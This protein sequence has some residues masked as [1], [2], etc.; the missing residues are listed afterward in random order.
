M[1]EKPRETQAELHV[2]ELKEKVN[3]SSL[4]KHRIFSFISVDGDVSEY[5]RMVRKAVEQDQMFGRFFIAEPDFEFFNFTIEELTTVLW[6]ML[7][8]KGATVADRQ[9]LEEAVRETET[10]KEFFKAFHRALPDHLHI[11]KGMAW[12][13]ALVDYTNAHWNRPDGS[14]RQIVSAI[15]TALGSRRYN[16]VRSKA[17]YV[18]DLQTGRLV[19][20][21]K[22]E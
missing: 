11:N 20:K 16:Y 7:E 19:E 3:N 5:A 10:S 4:M 2:V 12:G 17:E 1:T 21:K 9:T 18:V 15:Q 22:H 14:E 8:R 6:Q 13:E